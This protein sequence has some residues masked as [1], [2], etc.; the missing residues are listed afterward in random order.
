MSFVFLMR[1]IKGEIYKI[2]ICVHIILPAK[3]YCSQDTHGRVW[4]VFQ[5]VVKEPLRDTT[6]SKWETLVKLW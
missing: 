2:P 6:Q 1:E 4:A 5:F 3:S